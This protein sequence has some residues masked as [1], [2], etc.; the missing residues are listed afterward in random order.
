MILSTIACILEDALIQNF[1][2][3][4]R[5]S[6]AHIEHGRFSL[7]CFYD[8]L[9]RSVSVDLFGNKS[10]ME[11]YNVQKAISNA[12]DKDKIDNEVM[13]Q[14]L[15]DGRESEYEWDIR[16]ALDHSPLYR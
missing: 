11:L 3:D 1:D 10:G 15:E 4:R 13:I 14:E 9:S 12:I 8:E 16:D 6:F 7:E 5:T 2:Y